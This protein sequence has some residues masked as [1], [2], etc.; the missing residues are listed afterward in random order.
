[1]P[2]RE[3]VAP[4]KE[5]LQG[6][7]ACL[8]IFVAGTAAALLVVGAAV[9]VAK[10]F[11]SSLLSGSGGQAG[12]EPRESLPPGQLDLCRQMH[13]SLEG[14]YLI[15][16][17]DSGEPNDTVEDESS[18]EVR[19]VTDDC[20][21]EIESRSKP[22]SERVTWDFN[23]SYRAIADASGGDS[24]E[25][26]ADDD[27]KSRKERLD[28]Y[29]SEVGVET[30]TGEVGDDAYYMN[31]L[32]GDDPDSVLYVLLVKTNSSIYEMRMS[33]GGVDGGVENIDPD[34]FDEVVYSVD[35]DIDWRLNN[36]IN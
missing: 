25:S 35:E 13:S 32:S 20:R 16:R 23:L 30:Q 5:G 18:T 22:E 10:T 15:E 17:K 1:M 21:W 8:V 7:R 28:G 6:W 11:F 31:G 36:W 29:F 26:I 12:A 33:G 9:G 27:F 3:S 2:E 19:T 34:H 4:K 24:K 14:G